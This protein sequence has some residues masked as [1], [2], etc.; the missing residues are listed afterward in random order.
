MDNLP[1]DKARKECSTFSWNLL[2][3]I[4]VLDAKAKLNNESENEELTK[5]YD[6][7]LEHHCKYLVSEVVH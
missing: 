5:A 7:L 1:F 6:M 2:S 3:S 4:S